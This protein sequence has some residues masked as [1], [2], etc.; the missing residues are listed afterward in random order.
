MEEPTDSAGASGALEAVSPPEPAAP[1]SADTEAPRRKLV[2][3]TGAYNRSTYLDRSGDELFVTR[4]VMKEIERFKDKNPVGTHIRTV[5]K[6]TERDPVE[7]DIAKVK[8]FA[9]LTGDLPFLSANDIGCIAL[10]LRLQV[11]S[12]DTSR[13]RSEPLPLSLTK[14]GSKA[15]KNEA[16]KKRG[17][18][19]KPKKGGSESG[20]GFDC[21]ITPENVHSYNISAAAPE[22]HQKVACMTTDFAMQN[23]LLH[24][25]L[26]VVTLDG[27]AAKSVRSWGH[28]CRA[29]LEVFPNT[30]R[31]FCSN[32]GNATVD[33]V[34]LVV[35]GQTGQVTVKDTRKWINTRGTI[36]TQ[37]KPVTGKS[38][39][40]YIVAEDQLMMPRYRNQLRIMNRK[41]GNDDVSHFNADECTI[42]AALGGPE[43]QLPALARVPV[44]L[45]RGNPN[46]NHWMMK[47]KRAMK[48]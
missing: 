45:G 14:T 31:Q 29:C 48:E 16:G 38:K 43:K 25:G 11:E 34:P 22:S 1:A 24:M 40:M 21:W 8:K 32:C 13:L 39:Q 30:L 7:E 9:A 44:G 33:R 5:F 46:S 35:D 15:E 18:R 4:G 27:F 26:N 47:H 2:V 37:P 12:G 42:G 6:V 28:L 3:D 19:N 17:G 23:V 20:V 10:T 41:S 36:Y